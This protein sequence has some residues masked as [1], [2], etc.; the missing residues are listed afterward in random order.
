MH[1][2]GMLLDCSITGL[3]DT[4]QFELELLLV[5]QPPWPS[6]C[7]KRF[8]SWQNAVP[9]QRNR[10]ALSTTTQENDRGQ[11]RAQDLS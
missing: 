1:L 6:A 5:P 10:C 8:A 9:V 2:A 7:K 3:E 11:G 4:D